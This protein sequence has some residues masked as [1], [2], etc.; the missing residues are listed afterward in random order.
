MRQKVSL[1]TNYSHGY[2][3]LMKEVV[4]VGSNLFL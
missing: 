1:V 3:R 4:S 2:L